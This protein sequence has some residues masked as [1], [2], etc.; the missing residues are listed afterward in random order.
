[1]ED[2][3]R[4]CHSLWA[5]HSKALAHG[6]IVARP[7][8]LEH[9]TSLFP[10]RARYLRDRAELLAG[11]DQWREWVKPGP[12]DPLTD[13][14][15]L[16]F[17]TMRCSAVLGSTEPELEDALLLV[18]NRQA[19]LQPGGKSSATEILAA[20]H[21]ELAGQQDG[22]PGFQWKGS[23]PK[24][25][26]PAHLPGLVALYGWKYDLIIVMPRVDQALLS[27]I[28]W[29]KVRDLVS[30]EFSGIMLATPWQ[31]RLVT[32]VD[33]AQDLYL[34]SFD[35]VWGSDLLADCQPTR[36][37]LLRTAAALPLRNLL[38][39]FPADYVIAREEELG[40][41]IHD[42]QNMLLN[43]QLRNELLARMRGLSSQRPPEPLPGRET[44][45]HQRMAANFGHFR[46]WAE[47][48]VSDWLQSGTDKLEN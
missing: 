9:Y 11:T 31:L 38:E 40:D 23:P 12:T 13:L 15:H 5:R 34:R 16:A 29:V 10:S 22:Y 26:P 42:A 47:H 43:I 24:N 30:N 44:P 28:D 18:A 4:A 33:M 7:I 3:R 32:C 6:P 41:L 2:V 20:L 46:W 25:A 37:H 27:V 36:Y 1:M 19:G 14:A 21:T 39:R 48:L 35:H 17:E 8:D 45:P